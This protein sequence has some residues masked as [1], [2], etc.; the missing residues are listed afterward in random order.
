VEGT[1]LTWT[2]L[3]RIRDIFNAAAIGANTLGTLVIFGLVATMNVDVIAR[4]FFNAPFRGVVEVV[5][6]SLILIVFLQLPDVVRVNRLTRSDGFLLMMGS[7]RPRFAGLLARM[8]DA[9][10]AVFMALIA[11][12]M[13]PE[14]AESIGTCH[15]IT[16]PEFGPKPSG[17]LI[18]DLS[19]AFERCDYF[20]TPGIF[21]APWWPAKFA[22]CFGV[23]LSAMI[24]ALKAILGD[25]PAA[26]VVTDEAR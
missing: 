7:S 24:F 2:F 8:I 5:I 12:T 25:R 14:F 23:T 4:G 19:A 15:F 17:N 20:G 13:W 26:G 6:F 16:P 10:A 3:H 21:E 9:L 11:W 18:A 22:I 1:F